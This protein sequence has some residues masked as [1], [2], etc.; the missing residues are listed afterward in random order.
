M[1]LSL[2]DLRRALELFKKCVEKE[3]TDPD[4]DMGIYQSDIRAIR[5]T[6]YLIDDFDCKVDLIINLE[7]E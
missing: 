4:S 2:S 7:E 3:R 6:L 5:D 1:K